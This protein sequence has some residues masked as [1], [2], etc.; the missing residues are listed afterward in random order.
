MIALS[1]IDLLYLSDELQTGLLHPAYQSAS[2]VLVPVHVPVPA[3]AYKNF[4]KKGHDK[5]TQK[6]QRRETYQNTD[7][8]WEYKA[9][10]VETNLGT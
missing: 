6:F 10:Q 1:L 4:R 7:G 2:L 9:Y 5:N 3:L 8:L